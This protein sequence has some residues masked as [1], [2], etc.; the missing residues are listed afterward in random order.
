MNI[1]LNELKQYKSS[2]R[3]YILGSGPSIL[4]VTPKQWEEI[5]KFDTIGFNHW[6]AHGFEPTFYD[7]SYFTHDNSFDSPEN[8]MLIQALSKC[9]NSK[10]IINYSNQKKYSSFLS[11]IT[12]SFIHL[13][14]FDFIKGNVEYENI[15]KNELGNYAQYWNEQIFDVFNVKKGSLEPNEFFFYKS[16]G[17]LF[18]TLQFAHYLGYNDIRLIGIDLNSENKFQDTLHD[19][20]LSSRSVGNGGEVMKDRVNALN[21]APNPNQTHST[22]QGTKDKNYMGIHELISLYDSKYLKN[23]QVKLSV[24]NPNSLLTSTGIKYLDLLAPSFCPKIT[25]CIPSKSNLRYLKTCIPSIRKNA[26]RKDHDIIIFVDSDEDGTIE[27]LDQVKEEYNLSYYVNPDLGNSLFGIGRAY[28]FCIEKSQTEVVMIFHA[29]MMLGEN[30]DLNAYNKLK[31]KSVVCSTRIEPPIHP[32]GGEKIL[33]D[34]GMWPEEFK[35]E[36]FN[37]YVKEHLS[38]T[39]WSEGI[40]A[41]WMINK[42]EFFEILG[43]HDPIMHSCREDSD[44]FNRMALAGFEFIQPWNSLVYHLTGRGAGSFDGDPERHKKWKEDMDKSTLEFI[45]KWGTNVNHTNLMKPIVSPVYKKSV[46]INNPNP[47]LT[48]ALEPWFNDG[49]DIIV[50]VDGNTFTQQDFQIIQQLNA[51]I[52]DSGEIG[53]FELGNLKITINSLNEYQTNLIKLK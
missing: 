7:L 33:M 26:Y 17:Q 28:D 53:K 51:I 32:N 16:R 9:K 34:F 8:D 4:D 12:H 42:S 30:A 14:H 44:L 27:W 3:I 2:N 13:N 24:T 43:G 18:A 11:E 52:K 20:P 40:F 29:D 39:K 49:D 6:Y 10:F 50:E 41:P 47:Q 35:E 23:S 48:E 37:K 5:N 45:R 1:N 21:N 19:A 15:N 46:I 25:F 22:T 38:D 31:P 36:E